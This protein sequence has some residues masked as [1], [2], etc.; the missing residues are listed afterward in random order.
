[1]TRPYP[2]AGWYLYPTIKKNNLRFELPYQERLMRAGRELGNR[3]HEGD[4]GWWDE[5]LGE[6][7]ALPVW[8]DFPELWERELVRKGQKPEDFPFWLIAT[9]SMQYHA[10]GNV[11]IQLMDELSRNVRGHGGIM[12]NTAAAARLGVDDGDMLEI[13]SVLGSTQGAAIVA[14]GIRPDTLVIVG[15]FGHWATPYATKIKAPTMNAITPMSLEL[16]DATGSGADIVRVSVRR[17][18]AAVPA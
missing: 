6:Y 16:T 4:V 18:T 9:K 11:D 17:M 7:Q 3:L 12:I 2:K 14:Q 1:M 5:Q 10:G 13:T 15:Q 8:H